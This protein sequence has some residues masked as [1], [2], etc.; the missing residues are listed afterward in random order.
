MS[1][2]PGAYTSVKPLTWFNNTEGGKE[3]HCMFA[4]S[5][6]DLAPGLYQNQQSKRYNYS[7]PALG[8]D[9]ANNSESD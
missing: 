8:V 3:V 4:E 2:S 6:R 7:V 5:F 1:N 9:F